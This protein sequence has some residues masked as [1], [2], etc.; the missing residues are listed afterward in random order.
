MNYKEDEKEDT[1]HAQLVLKE[2]LHSEL[3]R[4]QSD[5]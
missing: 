3:S 2:K 4:I 1:H 5:H